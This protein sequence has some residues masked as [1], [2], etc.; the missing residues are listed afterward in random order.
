MN[1]DIVDATEE[2]ILSIIDT[3]RKREK[4]VFDETNAAKLIKQI[5]YDSKYV[6]AGLIDGK[7]AC[8]WGIIAST[9]INNH[10]TVWLL[11]THLVEEHPFIFVR[12]SQIALEMLEKEFSTVCAYV[13]TD[14]KM[15]IKWLTWLGFSRYKTSDDSI[16]YF[17]KKRA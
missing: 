2:H 17:E 13:V 12:H 9:L 6:F 4:K 1:V 11:T 8:V 10:A 3:L 7:V 14:F 5:F 16:Y 15:S